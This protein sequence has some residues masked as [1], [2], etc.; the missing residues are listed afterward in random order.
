MC[1]ITGCQ[2]VAPFCVRW[3]GPSGKMQEA[4]LCGIHRCDLWNRIRPL[5]EAG[6]GTWTIVDIRGG[7]LYAGF[8]DVKAAA[9]A[10]A[11]EHCDELVY[12]RFVPWW[13]RLW[14][15]FRG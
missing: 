15:W 12:P 10:R 6:M 14:R 2:L 4:Y 1:E 9:L 3:S 5:L 8:E 7:D 11:Q 13:R